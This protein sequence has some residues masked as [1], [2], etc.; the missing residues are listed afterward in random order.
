RPAATGVEFGIR[1]EQNLAAADALVGAGR[2]DLVVFPGEGALRR[3]L[4]RHGI[5]LRRQLLAPLCIRFYDL[6]RHGLF[7]LETSQAWPGRRV[8]CNGV[9]SNRCDIRDV[10][11]TLRI[12]DG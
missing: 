12:Q 11:A 1:L 9:D 5:L 3:L 8:P 7:L 6:V 2:G 4:P 10:F